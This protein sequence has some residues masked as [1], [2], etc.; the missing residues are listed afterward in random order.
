[1]NLIRK[2]IRVIKDNLLIELLTE[3]LPPDSLEI[4]GN[5]LGENISSELL[6]K[7]LIDKSD[8][9][10]FATPRRIA[11]H[12]KSVK[13]EAED[14]KKLIKIMP[15]SVGF[16]ENGKP[17]QPLIKKLGSIDKTIKVEDLEIV[18]EKN[19]Q[20]IYISKNFKGESLEDELTDI[21][22]NALQKLSI[23]KV[24]SYQ[25][26][27]GWTSVNFVRPM[28][29]FIALHGNKVMKSEVLGCKSSNK[30]LGHRF[31][32]KKGIIEIKHA[33]DYEKI[34]ATEGNV[35]ACFNKR[36]V[37]IKTTIK[38]TLVKLGEDFYIT[39][40]EELINEVTSLV[41]NPNILIGS[42]EEKYLSVPEEC[43]TLTM[44]TNQKYFP[45]FN[46]KNGLTNKFIIVS[47][48]SPKNKDQIIYGNEKVIRPRL[49]DA[50]FFYD[51]DKKVGL[52]TFC[53][54]LENII[55]H[56]KL[57]SQKDR[58]ERVSNKLQY[59]TKALNLKFE[60]D[61]MELCLFSKADLLSLM[62][63]EFPKL[64]GTM[65]RYYALNLSKNK[66]F[67]NAIEDHYKPRFS[68]DSL[69]RNELGFILAIADKFTTL[70]DLF[71]INE[72]P[73]GERD[74][75][76]LRRN[77]IGIIRLVIEKK[78]PIKIS[79][80]IDTFLVKNEAAKESL[81]N[82]FY[83]RLFNYLKD[84]G[85][86]N[87]VVDAIVTSKPEQINDILDRLQAISEFITLKESETLSSANKR[88]SNILKKADKITNNAIDPSLLMEDEEI[89]LH[90]IL[91]GL[92]P[93]IERCL[94]KNDFVGALKNLVVLNTPINNFFEKVMVNTDDINVKNNRYNL[95][96]KLR[97]NL[98]CVA[99]ISKLAS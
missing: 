66:N 7:K 1:M 50:E 23:K 38:E 27:D 47:N 28:R 73:T 30:T 67:A 17:T 63:S 4:L 88:V 54:K 22:K 58:A 77:T 76:G 57:G 10:S 99:D 69:P 18:E 78:L 95:L 97:Q 49:A 80:L 24:M 46:K 65:G 71:S 15:Y 2:V 68:N 26:N 25:L 62:V 85:Y 60:I 3:E 55:Y 41:E 31:E 20:F 45:I 81:I 40:D 42:F 12:I 34:L 44:K 52:T 70:I 48:I 43:L 33:D 64:Q 14:E 32:S 8:I 82:F 36:K 35:I 79:D 13:K 37:K 16:D 92:E 11:V 53:E 83:E 84:L 72:V 29:G 90:K 86:S 6:S 75:F 94:T 98:N 93:K 89:M 96:Y 51:E 19:Q 9:Q 74:P 39:E 56:N 61:P 91:L 21:I 59:L 5:Q 87:E